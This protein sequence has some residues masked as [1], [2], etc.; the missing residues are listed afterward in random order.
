MAELDAFQKM[1]VDTVKIEGM[2]PILTPG[3]HLYIAGNPEI[4]PEQLVQYYL[5]YPAE[6]RCSIEPYGCD[7]QDFLD[8]YADVGNEIRSRDMNVL[9]GHSNMFPSAAA[10]SPEGYYNEIKHDD[11]KVRFLEERTA[12]LSSFIEALALGKDDYITVLEE[13]D[14]NNANF[15]ELL[16]GGLLYEDEEWIEYVDSV[17]GSVGEE[18]DGQLGAGLGTWSDGYLVEP[19]ARSEAL[20]Y[21]DFHVY[22]METRNDAGEL[23]NN[24]QNLVDWID[25]VR[26][27]D[28]SKR[29]TIGESWLYKVD[30]D[31]QAAIE[32]DYVQV[33]SRDVYSFWEPLDQRW[34]EVFYKVVHSKELSVWLPYWTTYFFKYVEYDDPAATAFREDE[35]YRGLSEYASQ[36]ISGAVE[37]Y[38]AGEGGLTGTGDTYC[39]IMAR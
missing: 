16:E 18:F 24:Y 38:V 30:P 21:I 27:I 34:L 9:L 12:E 22:Q 6:F 1:G 7:T 17:V 11:P 23:I 13:P 19:F 39:E 4:I 25:A 33:F 20:D 36:S 8:Y 28:P 15:G 29:V 3:Y 31:E 5:A 2:F 37:A 26:A 10:V 35:D 32:A 14:L